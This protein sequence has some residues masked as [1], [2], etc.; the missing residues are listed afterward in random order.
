MQHT[1]YIIRSRFFQFSIFYFYNRVHF[2]FS[3][4]MLYRTIHHYLS[5]PPFKRALVFERMQRF[6]YLDKTFLQ[7]FFSFLFIFRIAKTYDK[8]PG[9]KKSIKLILGKPF[10]IN[11]I[12]Y[13]LFTVFQYN[14]LHDYHI[15]SGSIT[16]K[17]L[18]LVMIRGKYSS[19]R[20]N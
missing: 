12:Q 5:Y 14:S 10:P 9:C 7:N 8:H 2:G 20:L 18:G 6:K 1:H 13:Q 11:T 19:Q 3:P 16:N 17:W 4:V 15:P